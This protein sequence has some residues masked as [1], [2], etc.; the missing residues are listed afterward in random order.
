MA[1][2]VAKD[3]V[4]IS[5]PSGSGKTTICQ[6]LVLGGGFHYARSDTTRPRRA[7]D[8]DEY[9]F[10]SRE[11]FERGIAL[12]R[13]IEWATVY[14]ELYGKPRDEIE[15]A[16]AAGVRCLLN[17]DIQGA[18]TLR[19]LGIEGVY[20]FVLPPSIEALRQRLIRR[21]D[22]P[23]DIERR[24]AVAEREMAEQTRYD[25]VVVNDDL[26]GVVLRIRGILA[27]GAVAEGARADG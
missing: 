20:I 8:G 1:K 7:A 24:L 9:R 18:R 5:G 25:H 11:E 27:G 22:R 23:Q 17:I 19:R 10:I 3:V 13:Y 4:V 14:G 12:G 16:R 6:R 2:P 15:H 21:G 26:D